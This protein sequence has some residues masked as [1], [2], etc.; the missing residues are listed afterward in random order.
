MSETE[1][2]TI[3]QI[4][5]VFRDTKANLDILV[6]LRDGAL[7][8]GTDTTTLY[9]Q[10]GD[11]AANWE[12]VST[13]VPA[14][15][16]LVSGLILMWHGTIANI[17]SG[18][19]L[20]DGNSGTPNLLDRFVQSVLNAG[21]DPGGIGGATAK[22]T[23]GHLHSQPTHTHTVNIELT[24]VGGGQNVGKDGVTSASGNDNT[25]SQSDTITDIR[26]KFYEVAFIM[27]T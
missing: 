22:T 4:R 16:L 7:A 17:P 20:C 15:S 25:G 27:K 26:P 24:E 9:R 10:N 21:V 13:N 1:L 12:A 2:T 3:P 6:G 18:W 23:S 11:G 5:R 8:Y 14:A 19:V